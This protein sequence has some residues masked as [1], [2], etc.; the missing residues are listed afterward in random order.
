MT[1]ASARTQ[2]IECLEARK[3]IFDDVS[4]DLDSHAPKPA[5]AGAVQSLSAGL[6]QVPPCSRQ[7]WL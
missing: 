6:V 3:S 4:P 2:G 1:S 7:E 5:G